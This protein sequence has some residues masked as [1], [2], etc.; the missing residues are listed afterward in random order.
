MA[1]SRPPKHQF[2]GEKCDGSKEDFDAGNEG[3]WAHQTEEAKNRSVSQ[4]V[5]VAINHLNGARWGM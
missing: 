2:H 5:S 1:W 4:N 3:L